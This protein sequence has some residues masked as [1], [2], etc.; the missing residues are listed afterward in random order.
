[1]IIKDTNTVFSLIPPG[2]PNPPLP[3]SGPLFNP[4]LNFNNSSRSTLNS[5]NIGLSQ[6]LPPIQFLNPYNQNYSLFSPKNNN[7]PHYDENLILNN[8]EPIEIKPST[9][10]PLF[11]N[12]YNYHLHELL[13]INDQFHKFHMTHPR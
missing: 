12:H 13:A 1:M 6:P 9:D 11:R 3:Q 2:F 5:S 7:L 10:S 8:D 4:L